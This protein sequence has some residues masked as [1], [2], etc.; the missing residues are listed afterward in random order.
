MWREMN[1]RVEGWPMLMV[2]CFEQFDDAIAAG[3][4]IAQVQWERQIYD[5]D[6]GT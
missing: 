6:F 5:S 2:T 1:T 4:R 3:E